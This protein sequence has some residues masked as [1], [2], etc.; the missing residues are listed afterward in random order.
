MK[1]CTYCNEILR[2]E[3]RF[4]SYCGA[5]LEDGAKS[6]QAHSKTPSSLFIKYSG[7]I[8]SNALYKVAWA[9]EKGILKSEFPEEAEEIYKALSFRGHLDSIYHYACI[10]L[11]KPHPDKHLARKWL[12]VSAERGHA[13]SIALLKTQDWGGKEFSAEKAET[14]KYSMDKELESIKLPQGNES[15]ASRVREVL[16]SVVMIDAISNS[17]G[18]KD[19]SCGSGFVVEGGYVVTNAHVVGNN[20]DYVQA[21]FEPTVDNKTHLLRPLLIEEDYDI[22]VLEFAH[23]EGKKG[24]KL[25][26]EPL[27]YGQEVYTIGNP[28]G[29][30]LSVSKG[31]VSCPEREAV[32]PPKVKS[33]IQTDITI[34]HGNSGGALFDASGC[35]IGVATFVPSDSEGGI[36]MCIPSTYIKKMIDKL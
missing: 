13:P 9:K 5:K 3:D 21:R 15:F 4:C 17:S 14:T 2:D 25:S 29:M 30:G 8:D 1:R 19:A 12:R 16:P 34:N 11:E 22:A 36:G 23:A 28:L 31:I 24:L 32:Y 27:D 10:L 6:N 33:V 26:Y 7:Y 20:P 18:N 35:V